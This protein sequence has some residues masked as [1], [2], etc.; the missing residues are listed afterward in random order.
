M[1]LLLL[2]RNIIYESMI[3]LELEHVLRGRRYAYEP[4][5]SA[6]DRPRIDWSGSVF[7]VA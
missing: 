7:T 4:A 1:T 3:L 5:G 2:D 6:L